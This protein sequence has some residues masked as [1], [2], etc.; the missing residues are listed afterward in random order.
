MSSSN[1]AIGGYLQLETPQQ[2]RTWHQGA[3]QYQSARAAFCSLL[4]SMPNVSRV[5]MPA[6]ICD[7][8]LSPI[9]FSGK[10]FVFFHINEKFDIATKI[11]L[12]KNDL[13]LYVNY[14]GGCEPNIHRILE[15][16][17]RQQV[18]IDCSQAFYAGPYNCLATIYSPR[19]FFGVP[20]GGIMFSNREITPV[21]EQDE[22][23]ISRM[24]HLIARLALSAEMGYASYQR[25]EASLENCS[26]KK[27]S[28]LTQKL[29]ES[30]DYL[31]VQKCRLRNFSILQKALGD[32]NQL[33]FDFSTI[34]PLCYPYL[35]KNLISKNHLAENSVF[36][37]TY[38]QDALN[39]NE[40]NEFE[41]TL[42]SR[43]VA[44]PCYQGLVESDIE[45]L[46]EEMNS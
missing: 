35:P 42:A 23:S 37:P 14:F 24:D 8:M 44:I 5:W 3:L 21:I 29:L 27:M 20:D 34:T 22:D 13:L 26:P 46:I 17:N 6:Y 4:Q 15:K 45:I 43:L 28:V 10:E 9:K 40:L 41:S 31:A 18:I 7:S 33:N 16:Y 12:E 2:K 25:A 38:W 32:K 11:E 19:K 30:I 36:I 1:S 39:R